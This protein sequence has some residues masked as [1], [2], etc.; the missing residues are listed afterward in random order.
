MR[1]ND[2]WTRKSDLENYQAL[3]KKP[4]KGSYRGYEISVPGSPVGGPRVLATLNILEHFN[5]AMHELG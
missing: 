3:V 5:M 1:E 4:I 2:G